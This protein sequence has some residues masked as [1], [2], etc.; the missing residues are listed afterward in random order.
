MVSYEKR[1]VWLQK[2]QKVRAT[3]DKW[4]A[5]QAEATEGRTGAKWT[6]ALTL[7]PL[8]FL[9]YGVLFLGE[10]F[11][12]IVILLGI[13]T[14]ITLVYE[15][16]QVR[17]IFFIKDWDTGK[18]MT[19]KEMYAH[20]EQELKKN[21]KALLEIREE[22]ASWNACSAG[23]TDTV[24]ETS[25]ER[26]LL[27]REEERLVRDA[28]PTDIKEDEEQGLVISLEEALRTL[29]EEEGETDE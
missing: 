29:Q 4:E 6:A 23:D 14:V 24:S 10:A 25:K 26:V 19:Y 27:P 7:L 17:R 12:V 15:F 1:Q 11:M 22:I 2:E 20:I 3:I 18:W 9:L 5:R 8:A 16:I 21:R 13:A 28:L